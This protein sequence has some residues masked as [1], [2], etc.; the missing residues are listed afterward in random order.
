MKTRPIAID[1][2]ATLRERLCVHRVRVAADRIP[3]A[4]VDRIESF[5]F[6]RDV[7]H[8]DGSLSLGVDD[9]ELHNPQIVAALT[10]A[11]VG[12]RWLTDDGASL[13][14]IYL[15]LVEEKQEN[16]EAPA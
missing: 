8:C 13:E 5:P 2:P 7:S 11:G 1:T 6:V 4:V 12:I 16:Q 9:P 10:E 3:Q 15:E 14:N